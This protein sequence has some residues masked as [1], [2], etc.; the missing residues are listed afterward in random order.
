MKIPKQI[1]VNVY[2]K[3]RGVIDIDSM[4]KE[5]NHKAKKLKEKYQK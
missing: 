3:V 4:R 5:F 2:Q 1:K